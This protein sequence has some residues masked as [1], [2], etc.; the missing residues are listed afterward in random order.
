MNSYGNFAEANYV[1]GKAVTLSKEFTVDSSKDTALRIN[2]NEAGATVPFYLGDL[3]ITEKTAA[4]GGEEPVRD[5]ALPFTT[6]TFEDQSAGGFEG[7][8]GTEKLTVTNEQNHTKDSSYALK[9]EG[10]S[11]TWHGPS[12]RVEKYVD[13]G[14]EYIISAWVKLI[15]PASA[16]LQFSTQTGSGGSANY[17]ALS[18][19]TISTSDGWV[20]FEG[21]YRYNSVGG[22]FLTIY[23][24][25]S[26]N[27]AASFYIDDI[28]FEKISSTP[29]V[30]QKDLI[31]LKDTYK[32]DFLIGNAISAEDLEGVRLELLKMHHNVVTAG[33]AM[34]PDALQ[35]E[36]GK[37]TFSAADAMVDK[38]L[39]E[40][41]KM[42]GLCWYGI[43]SLQSG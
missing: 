2:S 8:A 26:N 39:A 23:I 7:R 35:K 12:L 27:A 3:L 19:K 17:V 14:S 5:P 37:F 31:P 34:K 21:S 13:K 15:D 22:E 18:P 9:V 4:G 30:I 41:K 16:Q 24:E 42:H 10:R 20:K 36:K 28:S 1:P 29:V 40:G 33:N 38:V 25:S 32:N 43:S 6:I 11:A